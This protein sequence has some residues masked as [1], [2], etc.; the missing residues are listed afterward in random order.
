MALWVMRA[1]NK[2]IVFCPV[3]EWEARV[4]TNEKE[5]TLPPT[6]PLTHLF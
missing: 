2:E 4:R 3:A 6:P 5:I 1:L